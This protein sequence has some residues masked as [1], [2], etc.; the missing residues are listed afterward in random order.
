MLQ[1]STGRREKL[2]ASRGRAEAG[3]SLAVAQIDQLLRRYALQAEFAQGSLDRNFQN[4]TALTT[5]C[6]LGQ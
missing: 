2:A 3:R 4:E 6:E 5:T 1:G